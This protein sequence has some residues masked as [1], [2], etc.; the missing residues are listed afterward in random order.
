MYRFLLIITFSFLANTVLAQQV[1]KMAAAPRYRYLY[2][3]SK[4]QAWKIAEKKYKDVFT[5]EFL[6]HAADSLKSFENIPTNYKKGG[7]ISIVSKGKDLKVDFLKSNSLNVDIVTTPFEQGFVIKDAVGKALVNVVF[8]GRGSVINLPNN[9]YYYTIPKELYGKTI[10]IE[11]NAEFVLITIPDKLKKNVK[12]KKIYSD[13][14]KKAFVLVDKPMYH[15]GDTVFIKGY[16]PQSFL[17]KKAQL[18]IYYTDKNYSKIIVENK[19]VYKDSIGSYLYTFVL[20]DSLPIDK[21]YSITL[22]QRSDYAHR[23]FLIEDYYLT[24]YLLEADVHFGAQYQDSVQIEIQYETPQGDAINHGWIYLSLEPVSAYVNQ[25]DD[26]YIPRY[27]LLDSIPANGNVNYVFNGKIPTLPNGTYDLK[28][29][30]QAVH[31]GQIAEVQKKISYKVLP[32]VVTHS[33]EGSVFTFKAFSHGSLIERGYALYGDPVLYDTVAVKFPYQVDIEKHVLPDLF[34]INGTEASLAEIN[35][36]VYPTEMRYSILNNAIFVQIENPFNLSLR[37][38]DSQGKVLYHKKESEILLKLPIKKK[39]LLYCEYLY[40]GHYTQKYLLINPDYNSLIIDATI[41][42]TISPG[43]SYT[44]EVAVNHLKK[45]PQK[46]VNLT[47]VAIDNRLTNTNIP[48]HIETIKYNYKEISSTKENYTVIASLTDSSILKF[49]YQD[50]HR[51]LYKDSINYFLIPEYDTTL[52]EAYIYV[53]KQNS[54]VRPM[55]IFEDGVPV[56]WEDVK[57]SSTTSFYTTPGYHSYELRLPDKTLYVDS[58]YIYASF[59]NNILLHLNN[60][61]AKHCRIITRPRHLTLEEINTFNKYLYKIQGTKSNSY[62]VETKSNIYHFSNYKNNYVLNADSTFFISACSECVSITK[63]DAISNKTHYT[64]LKKQRFKYLKLYESAISIAELKKLEKASF[65]KRSLPY[66]PGSRYFV[67][68][69]N[70]AIAKYATLYGHQNFSRDAYIQ[71]LTDDDSVCV[72]TEVDGVFKFQLD[73]G[74][75]RFQIRDQSDVLLSEHTIIIDKPG[76]YIK[77]VYPATIM[78]STSQNSL[79]D[80]YGKDLLGYSR[81]A[82]RLKRKEPM[83]TYLGFLGGI[84]AEGFNS[85]KIGYQFGGLIGH[86][87]M[88]S[89]WRVEF[90]GLYGKTITSDAQAGQYN[91]LKIGVM[92]WVSLFKFEKLYRRRPTLNAYIGT[93][94]QGQYGFTNDFQTFGLTIPVGAALQYKYSPR[95]DLGLEAIWNSTI[96]GEDY[97]NGN[98]V[99]EV[100]LRLH[101]VI[102]SR[103]RHYAKSN[104]SYLLKGSPRS[105]SKSNSDDHYVTT[106]TTTN[107]NNNNNTEAV[108]KISSD[109]PV[110]ERVRSD[111]YDRA[112]WIPS[113]KTDAAG[114]ATFTARYPDALTRWDN[115]IIAYKGRSSNVWHS[116]ATAYLND[117]VQLYVP[118]FAIKGDSMS[119]SYEVHSELPISIINKVNGSIINESVNGD[120]LFSFYA[121]ESTDTL[122][123]ST[124]LFTNG[125]LLD[126][127]QRIVPLFNA[128]NEVHSGTYEYLNNDTLIRIHKTDSDLEASIYLSGNMQDLVRTQYKHLMEYPYNCN[129]QIASKLIASLFEKQLGENYPGKHASDFYLKLKKNSNSEHLYGWWIGCPSNLSMTAYV[130]YALTLYYKKTLSTPDIFY[131]DLGKALMELAIQKNV[132]QFTYWLMKE[133]G[134]PM[135]NITIDQSESSNSK[136]E[137]L[138]LRIQQLNGKVI[139]RKE[140]TKHLDS[141]ILG[142]QTVKVG[143]EFTYDWYGHDLLYLILLHKIAKA[144]FPDIAEDIRKTLIE[145]GSLSTYTPTYIKALYIHECI[146]IKEMQQNA[147]AIKYDGNVVQALPFIKTISDSTIHILDIKNAS[148]MY[149]VNTTKKISSTALHHSGLDVHYIFQQNGVPVTVLK[150]GNMADQIITLTVNHEC[151]YVMLEIPIA[152]GCMVEEISASNTFLLRNKEEYRDKVILYFDQLQKG[153]YTFTVREKVLFNGNYQ[154]NPCSVNLMYFPM[155]QTQTA[156]KR[157]V[158]E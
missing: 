155:I 13:N 79:D 128:G 52:T 153:T 57:G 46:N 30:I 147:W 58:M 90:R 26:V 121:P 87:F 113:F 106:T 8:Y 53:E 93:G 122:I 136:Q 31:N 145:R 7:Y 130:Y 71:L 51:F 5:K 139:D 76:F 23:S 28:F 133:S 32:V 109:K 60:L 12:S 66:V 47:A 100:N 75:Y 42:D 21:S 144:D 25:K 141:T 92:T 120:S 40:N 37:I 70:H 73:S 131:T 16:L 124:S 142:N 19:N 10:I 91:Y 56:Y 111:F 116:Q 135:T 115:Y 140:I 67:L 24:D 105:V 132:D 68:E 96:S 61:P 4:E 54:Y 107:N 3:I 137:I 150:S 29:K 104:Q 125:K 129:E 85:T 102:N 74:T 1:N 41:A 17:R 34:R 148:G 35:D 49:V 146:G 80:T 38:T 112:Y 48:R 65:I 22:K 2:S 81:T 18:S 89:H 126:G 39:Q 84:N 94:V 62:T 97:S 98:G 83:L 108:Y 156:L 20:P 27:F 55:Y 77:S 152:A 50:Y 114:K 134:L 138:N 78:L 6:A 45:G 33:I 151:S 88:S 11:C 101:F 82:T 123:C 154:L 36:N 143:T 119:A 9:S 72:K 99:F 118:R 157:I 63:V 14:S 117:Y 110:V 69:K 64:H 158:I 95:L 43:Q 127:E 59:K 44:G 15:I 86:Q 149:V 103:I